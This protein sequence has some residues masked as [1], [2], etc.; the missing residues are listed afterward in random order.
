MVGGE[1]EDGE[2]STAP[3]DGDF[4][5]LNAVKDWLRTLMMEVESDTC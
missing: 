3:D 1:L 4:D 2:A 5:G